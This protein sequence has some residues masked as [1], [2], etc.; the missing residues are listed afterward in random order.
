MGA[1]KSTVAKQLAIRMHFDHIDLDA[2]IVAAAGKSILEIFRDSGEQAFRDL[3]TSALQSLVGR[4]SLVLA[5]GGGVVER[6]ENWAFLRRFGTV[7]YLSAQWET[8]R[9][10]LIMSTGRPLA[11]ASNGWERT[12]GLYRKRLTLYSQADLEVSTDRDD[13]S[14]TVESILAFVQK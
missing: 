6:P 2:Y 14:L 7:V 1:G 12:E 9:S 13:P 5:T 10:R 11:D 8:L 3:E 4:K